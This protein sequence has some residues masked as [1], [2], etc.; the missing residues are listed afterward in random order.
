MLKEISLVPRPSLLPL[1]V[2][3]KRSSP[4]RRGCLGTR[5]EGNAMAPGAIRWYM[6]SSRVQTSRMTS[7]VFLLTFHD[8]ISHTQSHNYIV[9]Y[10]FKYCNYTWQRGFQ[11]IMFVPFSRIT[12]ILRSHV[13]HSRYV[14]RMSSSSIR[15]ARVSTAR[16][17]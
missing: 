13:H 15:Y 5:L 8:A 12:G 2:T 17:C 10:V 6:V 9:H 3:L 1:A 14:A 11:R 4:E 7:R 16:P